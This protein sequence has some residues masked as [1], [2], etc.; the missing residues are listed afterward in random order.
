M[1]IDQHNDTPI[2]SEEEQSTSTVSPPMAMAKK[3]SIK[4]K[5]RN[6][7][8]LSIV[9]L[10]AVAGIGLFSSIQLTNVFNEQQATSLALQRQGIVDTMLNSLNADA[11]NLVLF[12][13]AY[14][15]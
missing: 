14:D 1:N 7:L 5:F 4:S 11:L 9:S 8:V 13:H 3:A 6:T 10:A 2:S 12:A 15:D